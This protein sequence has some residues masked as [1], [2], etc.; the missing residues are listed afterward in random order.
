MRGV[1]TALQGVLFT[2]AA[3]L[4]AACA[5]APHLQTPQLALV[6][7]QLQGSDLW[8]QHL[9]LRIR[10]DNPN[11]RELSVRSIE[12]TLEVEGQ[13]LASGESAASFVVPARG[14]TEFDTNVSANLAGTLMTLLARGGGVPQ[15]VTYRLAGKVS[16]AGGLLRTLP[17]EQ[18]GTVKLQ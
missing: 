14:S 2:L 7:V 6:R 11:D 5:L 13:Q 3:A 8:T 4:L 1:R 12:F 16:L 10:V 17:F 15:S 18:E 9:L